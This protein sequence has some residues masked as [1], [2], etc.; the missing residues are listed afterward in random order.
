MVVP[1]T[2]ENNK[3]IE[4]NLVSLSTRRDRIMLDGNTL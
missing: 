3:I 1:V 4:L 2:D